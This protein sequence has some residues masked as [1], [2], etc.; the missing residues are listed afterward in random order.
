MRELVTAHGELGRVVSRHGEQ[1]ARSN[2]SSSHTMAPA[3]HPLLQLQQM[4][5][6]HRIQRLMDPSPAMRSEAGDSEPQAAQDQDTFGTWPG[7]GEEE[8]DEPPPGPTS[9]GNPLVGLTRGDGLDYG[10]WERRP[11][12]RGASDETE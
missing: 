8:T 9:E 10:T 4:W 2:R 7:F 12:G 3:T 5:G 6:N 1:I 11:R